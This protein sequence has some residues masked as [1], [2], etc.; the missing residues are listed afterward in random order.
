M[1]KNKKGNQRID[2]LIGHGTTVS[3]DIAFV[4]G[5]RVDGRINGNVR[6]QDDKNGTLVV[7]EKAVICGEVHC[8][9]L[10]LNGEIQGPITVGQYLELQ[11]KARV[12]GDVAYK[13]LE[14]HPGAVIEGR[15]K[16]MSGAIL[17]TPEEVPAQAD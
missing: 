3:G 12:A 16:P 2:S 13:T 8:S 15:M 9:H 11:P 14:M 17:I 1:F 5:L 4:G 7:S 10:I 6:A